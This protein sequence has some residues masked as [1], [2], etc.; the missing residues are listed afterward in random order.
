MTILFHAQRHSP[1]KDEATDHFFQLDPLFTLLLPIGLW[2]INHPFLI[3]FFQLKKSPFKTTEIRDSLFTLYI[4]LLLLL[5]FSSLYKI[6]HFAH[7]S[8]ELPYYCVKAGLF[9]NLT[10]VLLQLLP[11]PPFL[12]GTLLFSQKYFPF[13]NRLGYLLAVLF[14]TIIPANAGFGRILYPV[15]HLFIQA[16]TP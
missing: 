6:V 3:T 4:H 2:Y 10:I 8:W 5:V 1:H 15:Y 9:F 11:W 12:L 13:N 14:I 16:L 7:L